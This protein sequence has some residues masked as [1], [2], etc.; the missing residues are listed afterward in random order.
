M[1]VQRKIDP[2]FTEDNEILHLAA[3]SVIGDRE[4][5]QDH[6]GC[7]IN[8]EA[9]LAVVCD[10]MGG[11]NAGEQASRIALEQI[12]GS[13]GK[14]PNDSDHLQTVLRAAETADRLIWELQDESGNRIP[15]GSTLV[16][17]IVQDR[18]LK[19]CS[20]GDSRAYLLRGGELAQFTKDM[21][22]KTVLDEQLR[23]GLIDEEK[24]RQEAEQGDALISYLGIGGLA[25]IDY[26]SQPFP[27][28][29]GDR[30]ILMSDGLY[31]LVQDEKIRDIL[32]NCR[33]PEEA[34]S[35]LEE[36]TAANAKAQNRSRDNM[37][38]IIADIH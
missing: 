20:V 18:K 16:S 22:Y 30:L 7:C 19:W 21:N 6:F 36:T 28:Q 32:M 29:E 5:Q 15:A 4:E 26:S 3:I 10:G 14:S 27:L 35:Q 23:A 9:A 31:R 11:M 38:V 2:V 37:T 13:F 25:L 8:K 24:Y 17:V 33:S 12:L 1:E 34:L